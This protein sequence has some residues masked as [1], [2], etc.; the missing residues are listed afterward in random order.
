MPRLFASCSPDPTLASLAVFRRLGDGTRIRVYV[1]ATGVDWTTADEVAQLAGVSPRRAA[2]T[3]AA[4]QAEGFLA[5]EASGPAA[6]G[7]RVRYFTNGDRPRSP[8]PAT[9][10]AGDHRS[11]IAGD[12]R[13]VIAPDHCSNPLL[14]LARASGSEEPPT[15]PNDHRP[16][17]T[18]Q[19]S[20]DGRTADYRASD[21]T[22]ITLQWA[23]TG[24]IAHQ[25]LRKLAEAGLE[26]RL[27]LAYLDAAK[28]G[29]HPAF[30]GLDR[31]QYPLGAACSGERVA[32]W[33]T[34]QAPRF[35]P[36]SPVETFSPGGPPT[37]QADAESAPGTVA[38]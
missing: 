5:R 14:K 15:L 24:T 8:F 16:S 19:P 13:S 33:L 38:R 32:A 27:A 35:A 28:R 29:V 36:R 18:V 25:S 12:H 37:P 20:T 3:L 23:V 21:V 11:V 17:V 2:L 1:A 22:R 10:I 30:G 6:P 7:R 26:R 4:L 9:V 31:A 34:T